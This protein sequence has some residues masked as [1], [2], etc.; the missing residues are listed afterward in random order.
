MKELKVKKSRGINYA[1]LTQL[2]FKVKFKCVSLQCS[3]GI[4]IV[5]SDEEIKMNKL[6]E[7]IKAKYSKIKFVKKH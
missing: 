3:G 1:E 6:N 2:I 4:I 7:L 5:K